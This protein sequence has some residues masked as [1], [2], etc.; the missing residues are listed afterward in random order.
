MKLIY[1][2]LILAGIT[3][4]YLYMIAPAMSRKRRMKSFLGV[5][6]AH[7]GLHYEKEGTPE[8]SMKAFRAAVRAGVGIELDIHMTK[9]K[10][11]VVFHD[12]TLERVC[13]CPGKIEDMS[14]R[15]L[16]DCRLNETSERIPLLKEVLREVDGKVPLLI[17]VK[18]PTGNTEIYR[19][20]V[21]QMEG[22]K[23]AFLVQSFN[24]LVLHWLRRNQKE[25]LRGQLSANLVKSDKT[26]HFILRF[27]VKYLLSNCFCRPDF[28]SYKMAD[29]ANISLWLNQYL[30]R[31]P[32]AVWTLRSKREI[33]EA[34][35]KFHMYIF[36]RNKEE[37]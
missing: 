35:G 16:K 25:I 19:Y 10:K 3:A 20:L 15:E 5:K 34:R 4:L 1:L 26:P 21:Q 33:Q 17:E 12:D 29:S 6:W 31:A 27:C 8:N 36:E 7:R 18:L 22:Y 24:C 2:I 14:Y 37:N 11:L 9:D 28:I 32:V 30:F 23:G 13:G